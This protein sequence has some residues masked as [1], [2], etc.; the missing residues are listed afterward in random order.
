VSSNNGATTLI[1]QTY[2][3]NT[4]GLI[5]A[6]TSPDVTHAWTWSVGGLP[7]LKARRQSGAKPG[8]LRPLQCLLSQ[9]CQ[10][11]YESP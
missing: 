7:T 11:K 6:I 1:D 4:K 2:A 8:D 3:R 5:T 9:A 10:N